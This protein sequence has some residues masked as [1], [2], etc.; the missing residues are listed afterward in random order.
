MQFW[1]IDSSEALHRSDDIFTVTRALRKHLPA[2]VESFPAG[3]YW[4]WGSLPKL[5]DQ[6][7]KVRICLG[8]AE[9]AAACGAPL[10]DGEEAEPD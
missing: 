6:S 8:S 7:V 10:D 1:D 4:L 5:A 3:G 9:V 2:D